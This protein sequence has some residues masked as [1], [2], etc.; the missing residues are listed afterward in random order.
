MCPELR[1]LMYRSRCLPNLQKIF[2]KPQEA[3]KSE[4]L[5]KVFRLARETRLAGR[6]GFLHDLKEATV[7]GEHHSARL[8]PKIRL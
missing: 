1:V 5:D 2:L 4:Y 6:N 3:E 8:L 7:Y